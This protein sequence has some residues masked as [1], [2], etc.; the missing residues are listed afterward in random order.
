[1]EAAEAH[2]RAAGCV[3]CSLACLEELAAN[4]VRDQPPCLTVVAHAATAV[5]AERAHSGD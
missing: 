2:L 5:Y 4:H 3:S 1:M